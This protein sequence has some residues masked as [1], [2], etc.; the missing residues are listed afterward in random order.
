MFFVGGGG[1]GA[2]VLTK[3][4]RVSFF[5]IEAK[6]PDSASID[7]HP[8]YYNIFRYLHDGR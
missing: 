4:K 8:I 5:E 7:T 2:Q 3:M 1:L 6:P